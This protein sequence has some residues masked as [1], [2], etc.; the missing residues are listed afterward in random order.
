M[1]AKLA[2]AVGPELRTFLDVDDLTDIGSLERLVA[3]SAAVV[4]FVSSGFFSSFNCRREL[5]ATFEANKPFVVVCEASRLHGGAAVAALRAECERCGDERC[6]A[7]APALFGDPLA[8]ARALAPAGGGSA[9]SA[10]LALPPIP[11]YRERRYLELTL[12]E[13]C[14]RLRAAGVLVPPPPSP[15][16]AEAGGGRRRGPR[17][18]RSAAVVGAAEDAGVVEAGAPP[19]AASATAQLTVRLGLE[20]RPDPSAPPEIA[21]GAPWASLLRAHKLLAVRALRSGVGGAGA[22]DGRVV[23]RLGSGGRSAL[24]APHAAGAPAGEHRADEAASSVDCGADAAPETP[25]AGGRAQ[26]PLLLL[27]LQADTFGFGVIL[28]SVAAVRA[29]AADASDDAPQPPGAADAPGVAAA[30]IAPAERGAMVQSAAVDVDSLRVFALPAAAEGGGPHQVCASMSAATR[31]LPTS[32]RRQ[33]R[34]V[35]PLPVRD[36][37][38]FGRALLLVVCAPLRTTALARTAHRESHCRQVGCTPS[39]RSP[40]ASVPTSACSPPCRA[41]AGTIARPAAHA[42]L[43]RPPRRALTP[44]QQLRPTPIDFS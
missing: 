41:P 5:L 36:L 37:S 44:A 31:T 19:A 17:A 10:L 32:P 16:E 8:R 20:R 25:A 21:A 7:L 29:L 38:S 27:L 23:I 11:W 9:G 1:K 13:M 2:E 42:A 14:D 33:Q 22:E 12:L 35:R 39:Q 18:M 26:R 6:A 40:T 24:L 30:G 3:E 34:H 15:A 43:A 4:F 28:P